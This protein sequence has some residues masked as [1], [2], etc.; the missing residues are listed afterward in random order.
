MTNTQLTNKPSSVSHHLPHRTRIRV[1]RR[2][3]QTATLNKIQKRLIKVPGVQSVEVNERTGSVLVH[4]DTQENTLE[5]IN[6]A[7]AEVAAEIFEIAAEAEAPG[8]STLAGLLR[9]RV[10][11]L[12]SSVAQATD[13]KVDLRSAVP[14]FLLG[15]SLVRFIQEKSWWGEVPAFVLFYYAWD[16]FL[17]L[18]PHAIP[19]A[20]AGEPAS[21]DGDSNAQTKDETPRRRKEAK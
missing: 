17:K 19:G 1:P 20:Y 12:N 13:Q 16:S 6:S 4:H 2:H 3:R 15:A 7:V 18:N 11:S 8:F 10:H 5:L 9:T 14:I 21:T